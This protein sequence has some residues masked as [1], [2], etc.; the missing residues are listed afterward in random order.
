M[1]IS[2]L[3]KELLPNNVDWFI[4][5]SYGYFITK[6]LY[7]CLFPNN[8][9]ANEIIPNL[10]LGNLKSGINKQELNKRNIK[11]IVIT[12]LGAQR[13]Y[14]TDFK[15]LVIPLRD[16]FIE[17]ISNHFDEAHKYIEE[18][19]SNNEGVLIHCVAGISRSATIVISY[20]MRSKNITSKKAFYMVKNKRPIA[21][22]NVGFIRELMDL[23]KVL[24]VSKE[25]KES[26]VDNQ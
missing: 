3:K 7:P 6:I 5:Y 22:P 24:K 17:K 10:W 4:R 15:Y 1:I 19:L 14:P 8:F 26:K 12:I 23:S 16:I 11:R 13:R 20:L 2:L 18:G 25:S 21:G 9:E